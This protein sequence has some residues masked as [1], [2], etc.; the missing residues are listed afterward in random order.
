MRRSV[1]AVGLGVVA[2]ELIASVGELAWV[3]GDY[4]VSVFVLAFAVA[5]GMGLVGAIYPA[6]RA[7]GITPIEALRYE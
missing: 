7:V 2:L 6:L 5:V 1:I 3:S 4:G